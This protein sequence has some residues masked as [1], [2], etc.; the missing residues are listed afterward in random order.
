MSANL[1]DKY[2]CYVYSGKF[3]TM[4]RGTARNT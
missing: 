4:G 2:H 3:L 1:Y